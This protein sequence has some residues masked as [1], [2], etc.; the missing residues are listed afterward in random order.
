MLACHSDQEIIG[1]FAFS[2]TAFK[3]N[4]CFGQRNAQ[5]DLPDPVSG[6]RTFEMG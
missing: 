4:H 1:L 3:L 5:A 6:F 2:P